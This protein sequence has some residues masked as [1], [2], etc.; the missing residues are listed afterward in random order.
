MDEVGGTGIKEHVTLMAELT[1][2]LSP[3]GSLRKE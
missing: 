1:S 2:P 3:Q